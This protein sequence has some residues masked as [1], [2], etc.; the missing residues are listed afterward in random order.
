VAIGGG[1]PPSGQRSRDP[2]HFWTKTVTKL[3]AKI[4]VGVVP[5]PVFRAFADIRIRCHVAAFEKAINRVWVD[6]AAHTLVSPLPDSRMIM[7]ARPILS[8]PR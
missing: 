4:K 1:T 2:R 5:T 3:L 7:S 8:G 6:A